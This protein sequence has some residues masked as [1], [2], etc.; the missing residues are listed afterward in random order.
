MTPRGGESD[1]KAHRGAIT[2]QGSR[3]LRWAAVKAVPRKAKQGGDF[4]ATYE[5]VRGAPGPQHRQSGGGRKG[6]T[7]VYYGLRDGEIRCLAKATPR[8][9]LGR[10]QQTGSPNG[11]TPTRVVFM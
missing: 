1:T 6:L 2:K 7:L 3:L 11:M 4:K 9:T 5:R 10:S 8:V